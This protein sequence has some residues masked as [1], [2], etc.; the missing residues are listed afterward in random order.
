MII[1]D[2]LD[3]FKVDVGMMKF[4]YEWFYVWLF[5]EDV[6]ELVLIMVIVKCFE[7]NYFVE[8]DVLVW[9]KGDKVCIC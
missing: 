1:N 6:N 3:L 5:I 4:N 9:V 2:I 7:F 8:F